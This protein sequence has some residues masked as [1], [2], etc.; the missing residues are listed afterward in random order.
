MEQIQSTGNAPRKRL[1][2]GARVEGLPSMEITV[3]SPLS[4]S[5]Y[6]APSGQQDAKALE[7][8]PEV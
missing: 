1:R 7:A 6:K 5:V 8:P 4:G 2:V 3:L